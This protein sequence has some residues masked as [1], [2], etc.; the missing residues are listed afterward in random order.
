MRRFR[1][2]IK[3]P[4]NYLGYKNNFIVSPFRSNMENSSENIKRDLGLIPIEHPGP[5][6]EQRA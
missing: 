4:V 3:A 5:Y 2:I 6:P 1:C